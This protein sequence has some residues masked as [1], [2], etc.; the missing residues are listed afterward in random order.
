MN[1]DNFRVSSTPLH[2]LPGPFNPVPGE[3]T[4]GDEYL[5]EEV[6]KHLKPL[7]DNDEATPSWPLV[8][9]LNGAA[10]LQDEAGPPLLGGHKFSPTKKC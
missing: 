4:Y 2:A 3:Q 9:A 8:L 7:Q 1:V 6:D 5:F 10:H